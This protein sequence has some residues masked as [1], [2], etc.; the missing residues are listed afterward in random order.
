MLPSNIY[1]TSITKN[2]KYYI[3]HYYFNDKNRDSIFYFQFKY[4]DIQKV[5][6]NNGYV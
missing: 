4:S 6:K 2:M 3:K 1:L 5:I